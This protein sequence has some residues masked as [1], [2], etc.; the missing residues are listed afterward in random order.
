LENIEIKHYQIITDDLVDLFKLL[1]K[2]MNDHSPL[3]IKYGEDCFHDLK[4]MTDSF[5][6]YKEN[7]PVGCAILVN[8]TDEVGIITNIYVAPDCRRFGLCFRL[9][10]VVEAQAKKRGHLILLSDTWNELIPMQK[11]FING[12][13]TRY[14][15][16]PANDFET[17]YY[18]AGL[19]YWK[20]LV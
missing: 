13:Y 17:E 7:K 4:D 16:V 15:P 1:N 18:A 14:D 8:K 10:D 11:A 6:A 20:L 2:D 12:G 19:N 9:F 5:I 3:R